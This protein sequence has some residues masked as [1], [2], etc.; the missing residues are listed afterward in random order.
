MLAR[1]DDLPIPSDKIRQATRAIVFTAGGTRA[2]AKCST[3]G[4]SSA[5]ASLLAR[6]GESPMCRSGRALAT[7]FSD[8]L[9]YQ[10]MLCRYDTYALKCQDIFSVHGVSGRPRPVRD[11][12]ARNTRRRLRCVQTLRR[13]VRAG[14][15]LLPESVQDNAGG[16]E[17]EDRSR[18][19]QGNL[20]EAGHHVPRGLRA[21]AHLQATPAT[22]MALQTPRPSM[23]LHRSPLLRQRPVRGAD[24]FLLRVAA[25]RS[26]R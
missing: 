18:P 12:P 14:E 15:G 1:S 19:R 16:R 26:A 23:A 6:S 8:I 22:L 10:N 3:S 4:S 9:H 21:V 20:R 13:E 5:L 24:G 7:V 25:H 11:K 17:E 2:T